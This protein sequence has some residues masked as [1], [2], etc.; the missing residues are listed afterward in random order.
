M[1]G[2]MYSGMDNFYFTP[3]GFC[4]DLLCFPIIITTLRVYPSYS[5]NFSAK[6]LQNRIFY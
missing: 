1:G 6:Y 3:T 4:H 2:T 5:G